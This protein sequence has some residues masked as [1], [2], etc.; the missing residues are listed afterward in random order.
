MESLYKLRSAEQKFKG[1]VVAHDMTVKEREEC[2]SLVAEAKQLASQDTLGNFISGS[3]LPGTDENQQNQS[4]ELSSNKSKLEEI[5]IMYTNADGLINKRQELKALIN[6][7]KGYSNVLAV[8][9][10]KPKNMSQQLLTSEFNLPGYSFFTNGL[11]DQ[12]K[13]RLLLYISA[14]IE[15]SLVE[16][17]SAFSEC[18]F[19]I[20]KNKNKTNSLLVGNIYPQYCSR[21]AR[22]IMMTGC[23]NC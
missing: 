22:Q 10:I 18:L 9:E 16:I 7:A 12:T 13:R 6:S 15:T 23:T 3:R 2:R 14:D 1:V 5:S 19:V 11:D 8:T 21:V 20:L 17:P 4:R